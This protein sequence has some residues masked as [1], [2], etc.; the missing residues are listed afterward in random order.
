MACDIPSHAYQFTF[1]SN[2]RWSS[3][4]VGGAEILEYLKNVA[5]KYDATKYMKFNHLIQDAVW[6]DNK[7]QWIVHITK[8]DTGEQV[9]DTADVVISAVGTL[10][11][12][13]WPSIPGLDLFKGPKMHSANW[14]KDFK[15]DGKTV[16]LIGGGSSG[17]QI[18]PQIQP[19]AAHIHHYM[20][21]KTWIPPVGFGGQALVERGGDR[22]LDYIPFPDHE[23]SDLH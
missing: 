9:I 19:K 8:T 13:K 20:K 10:N 21:G 6:D 12:W 14:K 17:I 23:Y 16:A 3:Y 5:T 4:Y 18:L 7:G 15:V 11:A 2:P 1:E 22:M